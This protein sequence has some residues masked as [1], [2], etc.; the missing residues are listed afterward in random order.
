MECN[1]IPDF[2]AGN[3][4]ANYKTNDNPP[5][6][7]GRWI[8]RQRSAYVKDKLTAEYV[9]KLNLIGLKWS[10]HERR[11]PTADQTPSSK[12]QSNCT[13]SAAATRV[14]HEKPDTVP[15]CCPKVAPPP[16]ASPAV[17]EKPKPLAFATI[18]TP[19]RES[20]DAKP[21]HAK[22]INV[23]RHDS[24]PSSTA[25]SLNGKPT[26]DSD[27]EP[28]E[29]VGVCSNPNAV[30]AAG[31]ATAGRQPSSDA[32]PVDKPT[33]SL[34]D[35]QQP[36]ASIGSAQHNGAVPT[37]EH[38]S[39]N[40]DSNSSDVGGTDKI[41]CGNSEAVV[42]SGLPLGVCQN[43]SMRESGCSSTDLVGNVNP[44]NAKPSSGSVGLDQTLGGEVVC[45][46]VANC[47]SRQDE[48]PETTKV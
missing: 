35:G 29:T 28:L 4:P 27:P 32:E 19:V 14:G 5:R 7:L 11:P 41:S 31:D 30:I 42:S 33:D 45:D 44:N 13:V 12:V 10:V 26:V 34:E 8:N 20:G 22:A 46:K 1:L 17:Q 21:K 37:S 48:T 9:E 16:S 43:D 24:V 18:T 23:P 25:S 39:L 15:S 6:A 40:V 38:L 47:G 3:V 36:S 2:V